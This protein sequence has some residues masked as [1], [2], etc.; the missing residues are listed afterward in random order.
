MEVANTLAYYDM[1]TIT[2]V[3]SF[4]VQATTYYAHSYVIGRLPILFTFSL[5][6]LSNI[7]GQSQEPTI[8]VEYCKKLHF[9][10]I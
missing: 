9:G 6:P 4:K 1:A 7:C 2:A 10:R 5:S 8:R 3:E